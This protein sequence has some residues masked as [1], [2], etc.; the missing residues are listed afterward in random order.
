MRP[1]RQ[2]AAYRYRA[3]GTALTCNQPLPELPVSERDGGDEVVDLSV[4]AAAPQVERHEWFHRWPSEQSPS[5]PHCLIAREAAGYRLRY[6]GVA[7]FLID[8]GALAVRCIPVPGVAPVSVRHVFLDGVLPRLLCHRGRLIVHASAVCS[9]AGTG[10]AFLGGSGWGKSTLASAFHS[11]GYRLLADDGLELE[12]V[13]NRLS[14]VAAYAG[15]R[16]FDDSAEALLAGRF[17]SAEMAH[18]SNKKRLEIPASGT[19]ASA[20]VAALCL[21]NDPSETAGAD[22]STRVAV[23]EVAGREAAITLI[24]RAF[25]LD[26]EDKGAM[27]RQFDLA[28]RAIASRVRVFSL[29]YP[30]NYPVLDEVVGNVERSLQADPGGG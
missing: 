5:D 17:R 28:N 7:D 22:G 23:C 6:P 10:V 18:Y 12:V 20:Q 3:Y 19:V 24:R 16:L 21:L 15:A 9:P 4:T 11:H 14:G 25:M 2:D 29:Q 30:R 27:Q 26:V 8:S 1:A 13:G